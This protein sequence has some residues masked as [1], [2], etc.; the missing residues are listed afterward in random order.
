MFHQ[1]TVRIEASR[2]DAL[3]QYLQEKGIPTI[4]YYPIPLHLQKAYRKKEFEAGS[5]E[6]T[7]RLS[8]TVLSLPVHTEMDEEQLSYICDSIQRF[9]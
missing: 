8:R 5:F 2:R 4:I 9:V 1:Y 6:V 3:K 7:E